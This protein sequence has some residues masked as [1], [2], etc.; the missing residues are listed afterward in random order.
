MILYISES[1]NIIPIDMRK[2][3]TRRR[4]NKFDWWKFRKDSRFIKIA[5]LLSILFA[6]YLAVAFTSY[7]YTWQ[8]DQDKVLRF[9]WGI[10]LESDLSVA[11]WLGRLGAVISNLFFYWGFGLP[12]LFIIAVLLRVGYSW[13]RQRPLTELL[14]WIQN[15]AIIT[16]FSSILLEFIFASSAFPWGGAFGES[17]YIWLSNFLGDPGLFLL[18]LFSAG[19]F[20]IWMFNR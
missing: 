13:I 2:R 9:S 20:V 6:F 1:F 19:A 11:N 10:L 4:S 16:L 12:S 3:K 7:L 17:T 8:M 14:A 5:G 15:V 18:L